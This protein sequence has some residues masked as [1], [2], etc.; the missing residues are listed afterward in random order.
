MIVAATFGFLISNAAYAQTARDILTEAANASRKGEQVKALSLYEQAA[1][2]GDKDAQLYTAQ[3][4]KSGGAAITPDSVKA[5]DWY[6]KAAR[7]GSALAMRYLGGMY[8]KGEGRTQSNEAALRWYKKAADAGNSRAQKQYDALKLTHDFMINGL[9]SPELSNWQQPAMRRTI[10]GFPVYA[11]MSGDAEALKAG[12]AALDKMRTGEA[13]TWL[14]PLADRGHGKALLSVGE[15]YMLD[16]LHGTGEPGGLD[17]AVRY[18]KAAAQHGEGQAFIALADIYSDGYG[19]ERSAAKAFEWL[20]TASLSPTV[21]RTDRAWA[22]FALSVKYETGNGVIMS[23]KRALSHAK[24]A[25][26]MD[27]NEVTIREHYHRLRDQGSAPN[28][29]NLVMGNQYAQFAKLGNHNAFKKP[30]SACRCRRCQCN[31]PHVSNVSR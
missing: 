22:H 1:Q 14:K 30:Q 18:L 29:V 16:D 20:Q 8:E 5:A 28:E 31:V 6:E 26:Q 15:I 25:A 23:P 10:G 17:H 27:P 2:M 24:T 19:G 12:L 3:M 11:A 7:Q 9:N 13:L 4:Y 21:A